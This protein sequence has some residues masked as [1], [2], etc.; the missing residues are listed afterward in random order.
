M[1]TDPASDIKHEV[2]ELVQLQIGTLKQESS[3]TPRE[4]WEYHSRSERITALY[5]EL[6]QIGRTRLELER[7]NRF[8][9]SSFVL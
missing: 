2:Q 3:L 4:L 7:K 8:L 5:R 6:D 9:N 1:V